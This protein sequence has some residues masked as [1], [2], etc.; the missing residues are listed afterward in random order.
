MKKT[1]KMLL[2]AIVGVASMMVALPLSTSAIIT[3]GDLGPERTLCEQEVY[4]NVKLSIEGLDYTLKDVEIHG[5][6]EVD[7]STT[8]TVE[9]FVCLYGNLYLKGGNIVIQEG[10]R[11]LIVGSNSSTLNGEILLSEGSIFEFHGSGNVDL[12]QLKSLF[13]EEGARL[14]I[15]NY[16][17]KPCKLTFGTPDT[18]FGCGEV[19]IHGNVE[20]DTSLFPSLPWRVNLLTRYAKS[21]LGDPPAYTDY[22]E[23]K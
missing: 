19:E 9:R 16:W 3:D 7:E 15:E 14:E 20:F 1:N 17:K 2:T 6:L 18:C 4:E 21:E 10:G 13:I 11:L 23:T 8:L 5:D 22:I 12:S